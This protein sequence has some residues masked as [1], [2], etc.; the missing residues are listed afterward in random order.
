MVE[1]HQSMGKGHVW[2]ESGVTAQGRGEVEVGTL[3][4]NN[5]ENSVIAENVLSYF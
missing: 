4:F 3:L 5:N 2:K 1:F